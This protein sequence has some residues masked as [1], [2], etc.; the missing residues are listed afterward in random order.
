MFRHVTNRSAMTRFVAQTAELQ[1]F[2]TSFV[3]AEMETSEQDS[4]VYFQ[5]VLI[6]NYQMPIKTPF[7]TFILG[8][9]LPGGCHVSRL[10]NNEAKILEKYPELRYLPHSVRVYLAGKPGRAIDGYSQRL[11]VLTTPYVCLLDSC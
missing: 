1:P 9:K 2:S 4:Q 5:M 8:S 10:V 3:P 7:Q 11:P 6:C